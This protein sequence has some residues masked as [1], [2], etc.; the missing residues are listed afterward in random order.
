[1]NK[2]IWM[3]WFQGK[4]HKSIGKLNAVCFRKWQSLNPEWDV[5]VVDNDSIASYAPEYLDIT[6]ECK[7]K[8]ERGKS[9]HSD[10]LRLL[11]LK[12]YGGVWADASLYPVT[13]LDDWL[14]DTI[15]DTGFFS[16]RFSPRSRQR[17]TVS[18]FLAVNNPDH[19]LISAWREKFIDSFV[20]CEN[21]TYYQVHKDL[22]Y[23]YDTNPTVKNVIENMVQISHQI[24]HSA[25]RKLGWEA[26][27][28][29]FMYK[30]PKL[31]KDFKREEWDTEDP[32]IN[33]L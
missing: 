25:Q 22:S 21:F 4:N 19:P 6:T 27:R 7:Y 15:N 20:N 33:S 14:E 5:R 23:L 31:P 29:S 17:E 30:R 9:H 11:L 32:F 12:R 13:K 24:P 18:W 3:C 10:L 28:S 26:R 1:M 16:Y 8:D 2:T